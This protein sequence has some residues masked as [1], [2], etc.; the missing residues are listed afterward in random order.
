MRVGYIVLTADGRAKLDGG[1]GYL[2]MINGCDGT[3]YVKHCFC[4]LRRTGAEL[5]MRNVVDSN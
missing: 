4:I 5:V 3:D 2:Y 1:A